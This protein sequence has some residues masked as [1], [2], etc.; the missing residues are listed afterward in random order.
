MSVICISTPTIS[1]AP[2]AG[3]SDHAMRVICKNHGADFC[4]TEMISA[5]AWCLGDKKTRALAMI[6]ADEAPTA[7]QLFGRDPETIAK[8]AGYAAESVVPPAAIDIN[9]GC[10]APKIVKNGEGSA[11]MREPMLAAEIVRAAV[12]A[13][14]GTNI[15]V[16]VKMR[17][18]F[19]NSPSG[20]NARE[21]ALLCEDAGC[22][23][24]TVHG[25][26]REAMYSPPVDLDIIK[27][28]KSAV[29][30]PVIGNGDVKSGTDA[31]KM[32][33]YTGCDGIAVGR[34]ALGNPWIFEEIKCTLS[35]KKFIPP[36]KSERISCAISHTD[37][38]VAE[39][40][41]RVGTFEARKHIAWYIHGL[42]G[43]PQVRDKIMRTE[44][45]TEMKEIIKSFD[46]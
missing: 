13:L 27:E 23:L 45:Y 9:M 31:L 34:A 17:S 22:S 15:P 46:N 5:K 12:R 19:E 2:M 16:T 30:I 28:V 18:G 26:T 11:L 6:G 40:G 39:K 7:I 3:A 42:R 36:T 43:A 41:E 24:I 10:P 8:A 33:E 44:S 35:G 32:L 25:R 37:A 20:K 1:L 14:S 4:T 29:S 21:L 38:L